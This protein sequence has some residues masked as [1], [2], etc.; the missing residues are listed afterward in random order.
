[1]PNR[2]THLIAGAGAGGALALVMAR[3]ETPLDQFI[4]MLGGALA[5]ALTSMLPDVFDPR[6]HPGHRSAAHALV[7]AGAATVVVAPRIKSTQQRFREKAEQCRARRAVTTDVLDSFVLWLAE[8]LLRLWAGAVVGLAVGYGSHLL[9]DAGT[10]RGL[11][12]ID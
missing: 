8:I 9:L 11:P 1:M 10:P 12:L 6:S 5:R 2:N 3:R 7:P 4:E